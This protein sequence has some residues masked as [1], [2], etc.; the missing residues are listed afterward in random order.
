MG[1]SVHP[2]RHGS[3]RWFWLITTIL[4]TLIVLIAVV[5]ILL[6]GVA[7]VHSAAGLAVHLL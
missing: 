4:V 2:G 1:T 3:D 7:T 5:L 6:V